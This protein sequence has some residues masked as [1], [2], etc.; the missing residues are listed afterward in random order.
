[1]AKRRNYAPIR[2]V[3][4]FLLLALVLVVAGVAVLFL[5]YDPGS[6][7]EPP[8]ATRRVFGR[9]DGAEVVLA[10]QGFEYEQVE[11][12]RRVF[13]LEADRI[14]SNSD[15]LIVLEEVRVEV[16]REGKGSFQASSLQAEYS[17]ES[18]IASLTGD[19]RVSRGGELELTAEGLVL[20]D[21]GRA[22]E[23]TSPV[24][25]GMG[26]VYRGTANSLYYDLE[27][28]HLTL[29][30]AVHL[31]TLAGG[32]A[33]SSL[34]CDELIVDRDAG[35]VRAEGRVRL[36]RGES[37][38]Q[39]RRLSL[40]FAADERTLEHAQAFFDVDARMA[41]D[42]GGDLGASVQL[43]G[44][45]LA[46]T[47]TDGEFEKFEL[48]GV[49]EAKASM[50]RLDGSGLQ[51]QI[52]APFLTGDFSG[53]E[54]QIV[55]AFD[56]VV[57]EETLPF[58][59]MSLR[60]ACAEWALASFDSAGELE[61]IVLQ[62][63]VDYQEAGVQAL[64]DRVHSTTGAAG[65]GASL[66]GRPAVLHAERGSVQAPR[67]V[68]RADAASVEAL[69]GVSVELPPKGGL[70]LI[71]ESDE[72]PVRL[73]SN[74]ASWSDDPDRFTFEG[75]VRAWQGEDYLLANS[76]VG[77]R[78]GDLLTAAGRVKTVVR[79]K[80]D[81]KPE[82]GETVAEPRQPVEVMAENMT[83]DRP[84]RLVSYSGLVRVHDAGRN[85]RCSLL[86]ALLGDGDRFERLTCT[87]ETVLEDPAS[88]QT[89]RG[90]EAIYDPDEGTVRVS[91]N[92]AVMQKSDGAQL[93]GPVV[94]YDIDSGTARLHSG[95]AAAPPAPAQ[96]P[97]GGS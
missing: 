82:A 89:V 92:P 94:I 28:N 79:P 15:G 58:A 77:E 36:E 18:S 40:D 25:F 68:Y 44:Y 17:F 35:L 12:E 63:G 96:V 32:N 84:A 24:G 23:S 91:G 50:V 13:R 60:R 78:G 93:R 21:N 55:R 3:R 43:R 51:Q 6:G 19:V 45:K 62:N 59:D 34:R 73:T 49:S 10:G 26:D 42:A 83:Y 20:V 7:D 46:A 67:I 80:G 88:G 37:S 72:Q 39:A 41:P 1:M 71:S 70:S 87:G 54:L 33:A 75:S 53:G 57:I 9:G 52:D 22:L 4:R 27:R 56:G 74:T 8:P 38:L 76:L 90:Q 65:G 61:E 29:K 97:E 86:E 81:P 66:T 85:L 5:R 48:E 95:D 69:D 11:G 47:L 30:G 14:A 16:D 2:R 64:G 31:E